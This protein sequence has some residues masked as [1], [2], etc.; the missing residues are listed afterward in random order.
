MKK[1]LLLLLAVLLPLVVL[2][3]TIQLIVNNDG[4]F[5]QQYIINEVPAATQIE[6]SELLRLLMRYRHIYSDGARIFLLRA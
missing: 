3:T 4:F 1:L 2:L 6:L 5:A